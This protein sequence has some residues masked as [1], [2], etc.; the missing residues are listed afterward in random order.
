MVLGKI[1]DQEQ[2]AFNIG[3]S[4]AFDNGVSIKREMSNVKQKEFQLGLTFLFFTHLS[5]E[6]GD[7]VTN[8]IL[9]GANFRDFEV[10]DGL[11]GRSLLRPVFSPLVA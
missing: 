4:H 10:R 8:S 6:G 2:N 5:A 11:A 9:D 1:P 7:E 3:V